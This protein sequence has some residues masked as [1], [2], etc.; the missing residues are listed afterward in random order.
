[1]H[2]NVTVLRRKWWADKF[3]ALDR[4]TL[5]MSGAKVTKDGRHISWQEHSGGVV[6]AQSIGMSWAK[7]I[8]QMMIAMAYMPKAAIVFD[9]CAGSGS[10]LLAAERSGRTC[11]AF[12]TQG[13]WVDLIRRRWTRECTERR[14]D[15]GPDSLT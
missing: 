6:A 14:V 5:K 7:P 10:S 4:A 9:P 2:E 8:M 13:A 1:M 12:E 11:H 3:D 15:P